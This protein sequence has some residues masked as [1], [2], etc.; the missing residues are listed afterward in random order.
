MPNYQFGRLIV[1]CY[2]F[3]ELGINFEHIWQKVSFI[4]FCS[5]SSR[6]LIDKLINN[7]YLIS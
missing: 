4:T 1:F 7:C 3:A 6:V 2:Y 5:F